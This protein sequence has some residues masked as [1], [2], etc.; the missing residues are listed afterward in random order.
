MGRIIKQ[1]RL[2]ADSPREAFY[3]LAIEDIGVGFLVRKSSGSGQKVLS[4]EAWFRE[5][6]PS[7][8]TARKSGMTKDT[9]TRWKNTSRTGRTPC[10]AT[11]CAWIAPKN[12]IR[13]WRGS[14]DRE[15]RDPSGIGGHNRGHGVSSTSRIRLASV[16]MEYGFMT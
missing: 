13:G 1:S 15:N 8:H 3:N 2:I 4:S 9:G 6:F 11:V 5:S 7:A 16:L 12:C 14:I 10:S